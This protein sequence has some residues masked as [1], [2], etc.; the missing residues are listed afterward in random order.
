[1]IVN[2]I[3]VGLW[4]VE[5]RL[6]HWWNGESLQLD[7]FGYAILHLGTFGDV[8]LLTLAGLTLSEQLASLL[9]LFASLLALNA[10]LWQITSRLIYA[11]HSR[12]PG[13]AWLV[14]A[15]LF[16]FLAYASSFSAAVGKLLGAK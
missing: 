15:S 3:A 16:C 1:M 11:A 8:I 2:A 10:L 12:F 9:W 6:F 7:T 4:F 14:S 13:R 5:R